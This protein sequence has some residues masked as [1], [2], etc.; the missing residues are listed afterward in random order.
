MP[1]LAETSLAIAKII[2]EVA[3]LMTSYN[4]WL[5]TQPEVGLGVAT[6]CFICL[7]GSNAIPI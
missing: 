6:P 5:D 4:Y 7:C 3:C 2:I 1:L